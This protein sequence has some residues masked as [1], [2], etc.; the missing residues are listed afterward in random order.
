MR[1]LCRAELRLPAHRLVGLDPRL[2]VGPLHREPVVLRRDLDPARL[3]VLHRV[4]RTPVPERELEGLEA[5]RPAQQLVPEADAHH[6]AL[7]DHLA[8]GVDDVV[9]RRRVPGP[10]GEK[11]EVRFPSQHRLGTRRVHG[12][13]VNRQ[14]RSRNCR[15]ML[16]L[17]PV[18]IPTT[19]GPSPSSS[20]GAS[21]VT[22]RAKS[23]PS[24]RGSASTRSPA[25]ASDMSAG[26]IPPRM[27][28]RSRMWRTRA[29]V[30]IPSMPRTP[31][32]SSQSIQPPFGA[33]RVFGVLRLAHDHPASVDAVGLHRLRGDAVVPDQRIGEGD[34]LARVGGVGDRLL[35]AGHGG[36]EDHLPGDPGQARVAV[37]AAVEPR[38]VLEQHVAGAF[39]GLGH[40]GFGA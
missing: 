25:S 37:Q 29:R 12:S 31:Q 3:E 6:R 28:P 17:I 32:P 21:G 2:A 15:M 39:A 11:D 38:A 8:H 16:S 27:A 26:K 9:E 7:A 18:S 30:S 19:C 1:E 4:V 13:K 36:V 23:A 33:R 34:D 5:N 24:I 14:F 22:V 10:V 40:A 35:V 20:I